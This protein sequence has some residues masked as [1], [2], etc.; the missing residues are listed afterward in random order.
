MLGI[1]LR[2]K[3]SQKDLEKL[4][5]KLIKHITNPEEITK[6][7]KCVHKYFDRFMFH[8]TR[9]NNKKWFCKSCLVF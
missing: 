6:E 8:K 2:Q 4:V 1:L 3:S 9:N 5:K 7:D